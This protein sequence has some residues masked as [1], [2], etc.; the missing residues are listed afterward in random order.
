MGNPANKAS[1]LKKGT[2][3]DIA[4]HV[5]SALLPCFTFFVYAPLQLYIANKNEF[6]FD[7]S[8]ITGPIFLCATVSFLILFA[9][10]K[11]LKKKAYRYLYSA[12]CLGAGVAIFVQGDYINLNLG[13]LNGAQIIWTDYRARFIIN[14]VVWVAIMIASVVAAKKLG[15]KYRTPACMAVAVILFLQLVT[16]SVLGLTT[17]KKH[18]SFGLI[19]TSKNL[20]TLSEQDNVVVFLMDMFDSRYLDELIAK[21]DP[22]MDSFDN[23]VYYRNNTGSYSTTNYSLGSLFVNEHIDN[24]YPTFKEAVNSQYENGKNLFPD[25]V[26]Q[27]VSLDIYCSQAA[28]LPDALFKANSAQEQADLYVNHYPLF[29]VRLYKMC[30]AK[31][32]PDFI[33]PYV[34]MDSD[35]FNRFKA[36]SSEHELFPSDNIGLHL[37]LQDKQIVTDDAQHFKFI[38]AEGAHYPY[39]NDENFNPIP[40]GYEHEQAIGAAKSSLKICMQYIDMM[41][42]AGVYDNT[43]VI[44]MADHGYYWDGVLTNPLLMI[45]PRNSQE[46]F[47]ISD[48]PTSHIHFQGTVA[49]ALGYANE[50]KYGISNCDISETDT[51]DRLFYQY[52]L[53]EGVQ[54]EKYRLVE[55]RIAP[56]GNERKHFSLTGREIGMDGTEYSHYEH[57]EY[58]QTNGMEPEDLPS[59]V[60]IVHTYK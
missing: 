29:S 28:F 19:P 52:Y 14:A 21:N 36:V 31:F 58:C 26:K 33:K 1:K 16:L 12:L 7:L 15:Q 42:Q 56:E 40:E 35:A 3:Q 20:F 9:V 2:A 30:A 25:L 45:K 22:I 54:G 48:A 47:S 38:Y 17:E 32:A 5:L 51:S 49:S 6:W 13:V 34:W 23:F 39:T 59:D 43:T 60:R 50:E 41:K 37:F 55:Y 24:T 27:G 44:I 46:P 4:F 18:D 10:G 11:L 53:G 8:A 57:C